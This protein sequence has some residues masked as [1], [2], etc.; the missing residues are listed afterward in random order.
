[1]E[2]RMAWK[3]VGKKEKKG[4]V[5]E[6]KGGEGRMRGKEVGLE[7]FEDRRKGR[8]EKEEKKM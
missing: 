2:G 5:Y 4:E 1:M 6:R 3:E 7:G 8:E